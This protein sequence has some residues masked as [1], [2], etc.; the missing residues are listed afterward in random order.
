MVRR[1]DVANLAAAAY[2]LL[3]TLAYVYIVAPAIAERFQDRGAT[4][5]SMVVL[6]LSTLAY[7]LSVLLAL[8]ASDA[9]CRNGM[10]SEA[11]EEEAGGGS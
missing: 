4:A 2:G 10:I 3:A 11:F 1:C 5:L 8:G 7:V 6:A 9:V